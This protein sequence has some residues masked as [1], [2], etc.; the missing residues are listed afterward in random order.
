MDPRYPVPSFKDT[1]VV[2]PT[3]NPKPGPLLEDAM[4][5][6]VVCGLM[7]VDEAVLNIDL[8]ST[9]LLPNDEN[10]NHMNQLFAEHKAWKEAGGSNEIPQAIIDDE[11]AKMNAY[12]ET[13][14]DQP[15]DPN[16]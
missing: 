4:R 9:Q 13:L 10:A 11:N 8:H 7:T 1:A 15:H 12:F 5:T 14:K 3:I 16:P 2:W 6:A